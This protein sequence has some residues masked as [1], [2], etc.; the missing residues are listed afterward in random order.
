MI[1]AGQDSTT[2]ATLLKIFNLGAKTAGTDQKKFG[3]D[4]PRFY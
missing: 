2:A 3:F 4:S 1:S